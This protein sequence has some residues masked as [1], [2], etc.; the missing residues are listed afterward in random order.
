MTTE[1]ITTHTVHSYDSL[2]SFW[3]ENKEALLGEGILEVHPPCDDTTS[4]IA[5]VETAYGTKLAGFCRHRDLGGTS[6]PTA[7]KVKLYNWLAKFS[8]DLSFPLPPE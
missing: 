7:N 1:D 2:H 3:L 4:F 8:K 6:D 5:A